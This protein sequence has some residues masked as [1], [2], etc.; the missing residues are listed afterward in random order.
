MS[1]CSFFGGE[2]FKDHFQP[3]IYVCA[4]CGHELFSSRAKYEHSSPWPAFTETLR[5]DSVAKRKDRPG[6][7]KVSC[8]NSSLKF[9]PKGKAD[10][11]VQEK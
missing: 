3:G 10:E 8:G 2:V 6:A 9:L 4:K 1:F 11:D 5:E 7:L